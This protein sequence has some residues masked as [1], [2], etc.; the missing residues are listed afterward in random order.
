MRREVLQPTKDLD[1]P[2]C[3]VVP[4]IE[5]IVATSG[6]NRGQEVLMDTRLNWVEIYEHRHA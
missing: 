1:W 2:I 3:V 4:D 5:D 6:P